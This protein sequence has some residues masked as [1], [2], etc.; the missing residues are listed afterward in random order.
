[1]ELWKYETMVA[2]W[3]NIEFMTVKNIDQSHRPL[4]KK[5]SF[6]LKT[7]FP[8]DN[9]KLLCSSLNSK[10]KFIKPLNGGNLAKIGV[11]KKL[12]E[13]CWTHIYKKKNQ[14]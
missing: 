10:V 7:F 6:L 3:I 12:C 8:K 14:I 9:G 13:R 11:K 2:F 1:M 4:Y 5:W